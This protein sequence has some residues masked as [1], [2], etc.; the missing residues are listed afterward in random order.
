MTIFKYYV[1][2]ER[3][4]IVLWQYAQPAVAPISEGLLPE[5]R[6][7]VKEAWNKDDSS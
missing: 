6:V 3:P 5:R 4:Q 7:G 1:N 2:T